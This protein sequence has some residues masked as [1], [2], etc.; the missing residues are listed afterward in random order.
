[1]K[2]SNNILERQIIRFLTIAIAAWLMLSSVQ[3]IAVYSFT[4]YSSWFDKYINEECIT[5]GIIGVQ[6][7]IGLLLFV[8]KIKH[9]YKLVVFG[10]GSTVLY[11]FILAVA[12][13]FFT[14][15]QA[16]FFMTYILL[17]TMSSILYSYYKKRDV[18]LNDDRD[19][20]L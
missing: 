8:A 15:F 11:N 20:L 9:K 12:S 16:S 7:L 19:L 10:L 5:I 4:D 1:M 6:F 14:N 18:E 2:A 17:G 3:L 13:G